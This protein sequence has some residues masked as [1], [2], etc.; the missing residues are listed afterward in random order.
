MTQP[1]ISAF[2]NHNGLTIVLVREGSRSL[3]LRTTDKGLK[4]IGVSP[5]IDFPT[6]ARWA[7]QASRWWR[8]NKPQE[9]AQ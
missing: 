1:T 4:V 3:E 9:E 7:L 5:G 8:R 6:K 2:E